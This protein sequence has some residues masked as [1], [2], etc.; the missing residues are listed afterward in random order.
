MIFF[1]LQNDRLPV[2]QTQLSDSVG[3]VDITSGTPVFYWRLRGRPSGSG[4]YSG[5]GTVI[6]SATTGLVQYAW[7]TG[8]VANGG[9]YAGRWKINFA[10]G[11]PM[12]FPND[13]YFMFEL[14]NNL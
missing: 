7:G 8:D 11:Q 1:L 14:T 13:S 12:S 5:I 3:Y 6:G 10:N 2:L 4:L 9:V